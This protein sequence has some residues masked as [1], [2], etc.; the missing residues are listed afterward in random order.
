MLPDSPHVYRSLGYERGTP[1][2]VIDAAIAAQEAI[3]SRAA[4]LAPVLTLAHL[5]QL[6]NVD[7]HFLRDVVSRS[8]SPYYTF[9]IR[10]RNGN[11][12][13]EISVPDRRLRWVQTWVHDHILSKI[14]SG[15]HSYA[16]GRDDSIFRCASRHSGSRWLIKIDI[17]NFFHSIHEK[18]IY[19]IF[20]EFAY[21][22][23][24]SFEMARLCTRIPRNPEL[25]ISYAAKNDYLIESYSS[26]GTIAAG[27]LPMGAPTSPLLSNLFMRDVDEK[28]HVAASSLGLVYTRYADDLIFSNSSPGFSR[29]DAR[30][31]IRACRAILRSYALRVNPDKVVIAPP[32]ARKVVLG[33]IVNDRVPRLAREFKGRLRQHYHYL[34]QYGAVEHARYRGFDSALVLERHLLGLIAFATQVEPEYGKRL[35]EEHHS[36]AWPSRSS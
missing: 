25:R 1:T 20:R 35:L 12:V 36:I 7:Y 18:L 5:A 8:T 28:I 32:G 24:I 15:P 21:G 29:A 17:S 22:R 33:L 27:S 11:G 31:H 3:R 16:Y 26:I 30:E 13:R 34:R 9:S 4:G 2:E 19:G 23:L 6:T 14:P 10:K